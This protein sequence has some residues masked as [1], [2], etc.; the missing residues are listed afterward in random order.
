MYNQKIYDLLTVSL[1]ALDDQQRNAWNNLSN[2]VLLLLLGQ[3]FP[4]KTLEA[5]LNATVYFGEKKQ[6]TTADNQ[7]NSFVE[8]PFCTGINTYAQ[9]CI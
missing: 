9:V 1:P 8:D 7:Q 2:T 6:Q 5:S 3:K 4:Y